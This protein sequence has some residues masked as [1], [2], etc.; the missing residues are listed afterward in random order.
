MSLLEA[1]DLDVTYGET[2]ALRGI[3][4]AVE[5]GA[6][7]AVMGPSASGKSSLLHA[8][9]GVVRPSGGE[10]WFDGR[11]T[12]HLSE[13]A[14]SRLR[15]EHL[16][17]VFQFG[18]LVPELTLVENVMLP[19]QLL[20]R[21]LRDARA[22]ALDVMD[23]LGIAD[24]A[25]HRTGAVSGGQA[26]RAAVARS[27]VHR[28]RVVLADEPTG[29]LDS[30]AAENVLDT[31]LAMT[32]EVGAGLVIVTHDHVVASH[33]ANLVVLRDGRVQAEVPA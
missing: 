31:M 21:R 13:S 23:R 11:R 12:D 5:P 28:P 17:M 7:L 2:P 20:R 30:L 18:D 26:Q 14:R 9:A 3:T 6:Q 29:S 4:L 16:G 25:E 22:Q 1:R 32:R 33:L 19:L 24:V 8:L 27:L 15:L 10:V